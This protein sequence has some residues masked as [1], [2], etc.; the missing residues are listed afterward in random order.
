VIFMFYIKTAFVFI[1][2]FLLSGFILLQFRQLRKNRKRVRIVERQLLWK[3]PGLYVWT[4]TLFPSVVSLLLFR[5]KNRLL[6]EQLNELLNILSLN[7][8]GG[9][10]VIESLRQAGKTLSAPLKNEISLLLLLSEKDGQLKALEEMKERSVNV[11]LKLLWGMLAS[12]AKNGGGLARNLKNFSYS[13]NSKI[14]MENRLRGQLMQ[15]KIQIYVGAALPYLLFLVMDLLYPQM[16]A[17]VLHSRTGLSIVVAALFVHAI[18]IYL[19]LIITKFDNGK[20]MTDIVTVEYLAFSVQS[21]S[22][23]LQGFK[24]LCDNG[25]CGV[26]VNSIVRSSRTSSELL[27]RMKNCGGSGMG[28]AVPVLEKGFRLGIPVAEELISVAENL[29]FRLEQRATKF[30]QTAPAKALIPLL[31]FI[32]PATYLL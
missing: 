12:Y 21:G 18:G 23:I 25:L 31:L 22:S 16:I 19:F 17:P 26:A 32:F 15:T 2:I 14:N 9:V 28:Y 29:R 5:V 20:D 24:D 30:Q 6:E 10:S 3:I 11:Y 4:Y 27:E 7:L 8:I 13:M 1:F